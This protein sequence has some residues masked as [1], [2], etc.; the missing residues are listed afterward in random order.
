[1]QY[2]DGFKWNPKQSTALTDVSRLKP[3]HVG[4]RGGSRAGKTFWACGVTKIRAAKAPNSNHMIGRLAFNHCKR[5][6]ALGTMPDVNRL[7]LP[8]VGMKWHSQDA[9]FELP[10]GSRIW[11]GGY[12][13]KDRIEKIL[14]TEYST[15]FNNET[16]QI[17]WNTI[18]T[19]RTRLAET[20]L[21]TN[22]QPLRQLE[23]NDLNPTHN[24]HWSYREFVEGIH[25]ET[26]EPIQTERYY[27]LQMNPDDNRENLSTAYIESLDAM[28][29]QKRRRFKDGEYQ[30]DD[31][32]AM[33]RRD[34]IDEHRVQSAPELRR[35]VTAVDPSG[36]G[37]DD[38]GIVSV[39]VAPDEAGLDHFYV[40][41]D[42][43]RGGSAPKRFEAVIK[44][45]DALDADLIVGESNFGGDIVEKATRDTAE[46]MFHRGGRKSKEIAYKPVVASKGKVLRADPVANVYYQGRVHHVGAFGDMEDEMCR[47]TSDWNRSKDGSPNRV[48]ALV[49]AIT[50]LLGAKAAPKIPQITRRV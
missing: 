43:S 4:L 1:M 14:G 5:S 41:S 11:I 24:R 28:S 27:E 6:I 20:V 44:D 19:V 47:F 35:T 9:Y 22:G 50:E 45:H 30:T 10:N 17:S 31:E 48:D 36:G 29:P 37:S 33:W 15:I 3:R 23:I 2:A 7:V 21:Q 18:E 34:W 40:L 16:S 38:T 12:D 46:L 26:L 13:D 42:A 32:N 25:P 39:G 49:F 8:D